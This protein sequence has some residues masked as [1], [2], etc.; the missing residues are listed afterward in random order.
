MGY[1]DD[2]HDLNSHFIHFFSGY[3]F[4]PKIYLN[5]RSFLEITYEKSWERSK[6]DGNFACFDD[7][8][9]FDILDL[10]FYVQDPSLNEVYQSDDKLQ[11]AIEMLTVDTKLLNYCKYLFDY[12]GI[13]PL[14][15]NHVS[16]TETKFLREAIDFV[17]KN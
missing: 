16:I 9:S 6:K 12:D 17:L 10:V 11:L 8:I 1:Y 2:L 14:L 13:L 7:L 5:W 4:S 15:N 3:R